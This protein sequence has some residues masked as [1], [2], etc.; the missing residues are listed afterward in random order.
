MSM[1]IPDPSNPNDAGTADATDA[2]VAGAADQGQTQEPAQQSAAE[3][4]PAGADKA[5]QPNPGGD[6]PAIDPQAEAMAAFERGVAETPKDDMPAV[7]GAPAKDG[8]AAGDKDATKAKKD[9]QGKDDAADADAAAADTVDDAGKNKLDAAVEKEIKDL[10]ITSDRAT[11]RFREL[12]QKAAQVEPL[13]AK[14]AKLDDWNDTVRATGADPEQFSRSLGYLTA[15]NSGD[16]VQLGRAFD[17]L[18]QELTWL[19]EKLGRPAP[20]F[21][22][23]AAHADLQGKVASG[24]ITRADAEELARSRQAQA[25]AAE[26]RTAQDTA[27]QLANAHQSALVEV[28]NVGNELRGRDGVEVFKAKFG[29][30]GPTIALIQETLPPAQW[31]AR[32]RQA[33][34]ALPAPAVAPK[35]RTEAAAPGQQ[36]LRPTGTSPAQ[37]RAPT[38]DVDAFA[39][40]V[41]EAKAAG[42]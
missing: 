19:A 9:G 30:L 34:D 40:G 8:V 1:H 13:Q 42:L 39:L 10:G 18:S 24:D 3:E 12:S 4:A 15:I 37:M 38:N 11:R 41:A 2:A 29:L 6:K 27:T 25:L 28:S 35:P 26:H 33:Y 32:I 17:A 7:P 21:D 36:P 14:A 5:G 22:P 23:L 20:G 16:P 31:S